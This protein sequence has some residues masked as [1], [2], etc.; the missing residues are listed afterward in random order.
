MRRNVKCVFDSKEASQQRKLVNVLFEQKCN[1]VQTACGFLSTLNVVK[2][3]PL[4]STTALV[5]VEV[6]LA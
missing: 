2:N 6:S 4:K 5:V 1:L 3:A